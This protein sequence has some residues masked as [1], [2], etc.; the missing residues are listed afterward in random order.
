MKKSQ[1]DKIKQQTQ[2]RW[3][4]RGKEIYENCKMNPIFGTQKNV[5]NI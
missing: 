5:R 4:N 3:D 1:L 2:E